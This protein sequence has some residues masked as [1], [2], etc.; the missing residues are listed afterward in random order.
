MLEQKVVERTQSYMETNL[1]LS[2]EVEKRR[3]FQQDLEQRLITERILARTSLQLLETAELKSAIGPL[4][5]NLG[6]IIQKGAV[7]LALV[8]PGYALETADLY[9]WHD[10]KTQPFSPEIIKKMLSPGN[11][12]MTGLRE[13][14]I[15]QIEE[16]SGLPDKA[17]TERTLLSDRGINSLVLVPL[18]SEGIIRGIIILGNSLSDGDDAQY[19]MQALEV[20]G[21][22]LSNQLQRE[23]LLRTLEV[24]VAEQARELSTFYEMTMLSAQTQNLSDILYPA[25]S[26]IQE[27]SNSEVASIHIFSADHQVLQLVAQ[28]GI[29]Q[30]KVKLLESVQAGEDVLNWLNRAESDHGVGRQFPADMPRA[31]Q[32]P[33]FGSFLT[34]KLRATGNTLGIIS[35]YRI[36]SQSYT[37]FQCSILEI[38]GELLGVV[39]ENQR[40]TQE[41]GKLATIQE[42]QRL[43]RELHDAV[44]QSIYSLSLFARSAR[45]AL[46]AGEKEKLQA[47]LEQLETNSLSALKEMRLLLY[48]LRTITFEEG[49][50]VHAIEARFDLVERRS[51]ILA[52]IHA[53]DR[54][55]FPPQI[56]QE[57][58]RVITEALNNAIYYAEASHVSVDLRLESDQI[59]V[60]VEDDGVGFTFSDIRA[61]MGM[62]NM[63]ERSKSMNGSIDITSTPGR[64]TRVRLCVPAAEIQSGEIGDG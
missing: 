62:Q 60:T 43:A 64:G 5:E 59:T 4:L 52:E 22:L 6:A 19:N 47:N 23:D 7:C 61:G 1:R 49:D 10:G 16:V 2:E 37:P 41:A 15:L 33:G 45:D 17:K 50:L 8:E 24:R 13:Y 12:F 46:D 3:Q 18:S 27:I 48:Q 53:D 63:R 31:F 25:L 56:E 57:F 29:P 39:I 55:H 35:C 36:S 54:I 32:L 9:F 30:A 34:S 26:R 21:G 11:W 20:M 14:Q 58:F 28:R 42:R 44:S 38:I 40:L 51:G